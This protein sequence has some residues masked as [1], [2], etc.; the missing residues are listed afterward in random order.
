MTIT[1]QTIITIAAVIAAIVAIVGYYNKGFKWF[2]K[3]EEQ[4]KDIDELKQKEAKDIA[5]IKNEQTMIVYA[6]SACLD[7]LV[8]LGANHSVPVAKEKLD[9]YINQKAHDQL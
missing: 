7:G 6:L 2:L 1:W 3:Q 4:T 8:Q 9:K 5:D